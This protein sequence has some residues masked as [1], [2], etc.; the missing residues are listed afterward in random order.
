MN[1][2]KNISLILLKKNA[3]K[4]DF[5]VDILVDQKFISKKD[6]IPIISHPK[7]KTIKLLLDTNKIILPINIHKK[8]K[9]LSTKGSYLK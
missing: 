3:L 1:I 2:N 9:N 5:N 8:I 7:N 6:V 4:A